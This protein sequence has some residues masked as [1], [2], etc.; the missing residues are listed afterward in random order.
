MSK[1]PDPTV[2]LAEAVLRRLKE[3]E[4]I[5]SLRNDDGS[6]IEC[7][8]T[9]EHEAGCVLR[10]LETEVEKAKAEW[11]EVVSK[12]APAQAAYDQAFAAEG[13]Y[14][15]HDKPLPEKVASAT[16][17]TMSALFSWMDRK[18]VLENQLKKLQS[19]G[20]IERRRQVNN[21]LKEV[22]K[23]ASEN[24]KKETARDQGVPGSYLGAGGNFKPGMDA[25]YKSDLITSAL[26]EKI[27]DKG[28]HQFTR[29]SALERLEQRGWLPHLEKAKQSRAA[30]AAKKLEKSKATPRVTTKKATSPRKRAASKK[31]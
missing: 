2:E 6:C 15:D 29:D 16:D 1:K 14:K 9:E 21:R 4:E 22:R 23:V 31:A 26:G 13:K 3:R 18:V 17:K 10:T 19:P 12:I 5:V 28:L 25:R 20:E 11:H 8:A 24:N 7:G 30:K 27:D